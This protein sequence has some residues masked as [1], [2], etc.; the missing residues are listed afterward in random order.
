MRKSCGLCVAAL[1]MAVPFGAV[2]AAVVP[3]VLLEEGFDGDPG[4]LPD[5]WS[6]FAGGGG[7]LSNDD[8]TGFVD[9]FSPGAFTDS[10]PFP[11]TSAVSG[12]NAGAGLFSVDA[13]GLGIPQGTADGIAFA[14]F[15]AGINRSG[16]TPSVNDPSELTFDNVRLTARVSGRGMTEGG[17]QGRLEVRTRAADIGADD[18]ATRG[19]NFTLTEEDQII[20]VGGLLSDAMKGG[21]PFDPDVDLSKPIVVQVQFTNERNSWGLDAG[22]SIFV[23][24]VKLEVIPEP[25]SIALAGLGSL[26]LLGRRRRLA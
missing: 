4:P 17:G 26:A 16:I 9:A 14:F 15:F 21:D 24:D 22:N 1:A 18:D 6:F 8:S 5:G 12:Q 25:A 3:E 10:S 13:T 7:D 20:D 23:H 19:F 11:P 2:D